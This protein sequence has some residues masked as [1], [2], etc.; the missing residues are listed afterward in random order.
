MGER[1]NRIINF[2][3]VKWLK[4]LMWFNIAYYIVGLKK[5]SIGFLGDVQQQQ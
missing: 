3:S 2:D 4:K 1:C 5:N